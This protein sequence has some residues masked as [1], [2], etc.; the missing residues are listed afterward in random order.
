MNFI[1][2][3]PLTPGTHV[4][5]RQGTQPFCGER[6]EYEAVIGVTVSRIG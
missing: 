6:S 2:N 4:L 5:N 3:V 1:V